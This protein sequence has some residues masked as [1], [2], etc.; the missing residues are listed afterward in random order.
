VAELAAR[1]LSVNA[2]LAAASASIT[3][4]AASLHG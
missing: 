3:P 1:E 2:L 4:A